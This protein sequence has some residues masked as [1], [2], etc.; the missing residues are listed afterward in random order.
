MVCWRGEGPFT[1]TLALDRMKILSRP[2]DENYEFLATAE[3]DGG[4]DAAFGSSPGSRRSPWR[5]L[6][7]SFLGVLRFLRRTLVALLTTVTVIPLLLAAALVTSLAT[8]VFLPL[9][10]TL[11]EQRPQPEA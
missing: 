4:P 1:A 3:T 2:G 5:L 7:G 6:F 10:V 9:P 8:Y 11:P